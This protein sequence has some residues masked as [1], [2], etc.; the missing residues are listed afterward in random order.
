MFINHNPRIEQ[1]AGARARGG[2]IEDIH[3][4][5]A[6]SVDCPNSHFKLK[7]NSKPLEGCG[8]LVPTQAYSI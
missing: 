1:K 2:A 4:L 8:A 6:Q 3:G 5:A 7:I